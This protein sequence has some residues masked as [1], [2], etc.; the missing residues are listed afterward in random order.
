[1]CQG[2]VGLKR[3]FG[4]ERFGKRGFLI[5]S[6]GLAGTKFCFGAVLKKQKRNENKDLDWKK[7]A[8]FIFTSVFNV[9]V[10]QLF[11]LDFPSLN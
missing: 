5:L 11:R 2:K 1:V 8:N 6:R 10:P 7:T 9:W 4:E 3:A